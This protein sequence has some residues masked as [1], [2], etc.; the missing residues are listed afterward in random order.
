MSASDRWRGECERGRRV[1][2]KDSQP[3][4]A[5]RRKVYPTGGI[6]PCLCMQFRS[7]TTPSQ[8][9]IARKARKYEKQHRRLALPA[10]EFGYNFLA[11]AHAPR[12]TITDRML[13]LVEAHL[14]QLEPYK[15]KPHTYGNKAGEKAESDTGEYWDDLLLGLF[16]KGACL[17]YVAYPVRY[18]WTALH[19]WCIYDNDRIRMQSLTPTRLLR[20]H[21]LMRLL[22]RKKC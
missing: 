22:N 19:V 3:V 11:I 6:Y 7:L 10:L 9:F 13:P 1:T 8:K 2:S 4:T 15:D 21:K 14:K 20:F 16:L 12:T 18:F 17:R 5:H